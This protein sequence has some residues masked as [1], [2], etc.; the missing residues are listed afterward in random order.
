MTEEARKTLA[1]RFFDA[2]ETIFANLAG[3]WRDESKHENIDDY[4]EPIQKFANT[5]DA[6]I[7]IGKMSKRPFGCQFQIDGATYRI[8]VAGRQYSYQRIA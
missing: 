3:R 1:K 7:K 8:S 4:A 6:E 2:A 5:I